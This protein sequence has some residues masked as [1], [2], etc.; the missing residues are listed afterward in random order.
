MPS[1]VRPP[2]RSLRMSAGSLVDV[3]RAHTREAFAWKQS[4]SVAVVALVAVGL[5]AAIP[6]AST[7]TGNTVAES[8][9]SG[10]TI[11]GKVTWTATTSGTKP[12]AV[13]FSIDGNVKWAESTAPYQYNGDPSGLL[14]TTALTNGQHTFAAVAFYA[15]GTTATATAT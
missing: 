6:L 10:S 1:S 12:T 4:V 2:R 13:K 15:N 3:L 5:G 11:G 7:A 9:A 8:V 14:D